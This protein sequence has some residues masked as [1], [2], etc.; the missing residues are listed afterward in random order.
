MQVDALVRELAG[1]RLEARE[2]QFSFDLC[3]LWLGKDF[4]LLAYW[5]YKKVV[6]MVVRH[7]VV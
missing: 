4:S 7:R 3:A 5:L 1:V 6:I 2:T